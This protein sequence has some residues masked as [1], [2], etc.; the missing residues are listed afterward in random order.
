MRALLVEDNPADAR[1]IQEM[2]KA[3]PD[4]QVELQPVARLEAALKRLRQETFDLILL[5]LGLPDSQGLETLT[6]TAQAG[7]SSPIVVLTGRNDQAFALEALR[8]GAQDYLVK[9]HFDSDLLV[10]AIRY[11]VER[12]RAE[13]EVR[14]LNAE[15]EQRVA[16]RTA[17]LQTANQELLQ[18]QNRLTEAQ[19]IANVGDWEW[20]ISSDR[21]SASDQAYRMFAIEPVGSPLN[22]AAFLARVHPGDRPQVAKKL[23]QS[24]SAGAEYEME[25]RVLLPDGAV[26]WIFARGVV[27]RDAAGKPARMA[28]TVLDITDRKRVEEALRRSREDLDQA[29]QVGQIGSWR[30]DVRRNVLTWSDE[31]HRIFGVPKG[32][33]LTYETFL[34]TVH[35]DDRQLVDRQWQAALRGETY[36]IEHR[37]VVNGQVK[38]VRE[39]AFLE[40]DQAG[41]LLGGFGIT[42]DIT[43]RKQSEEKL[44]HSAAQIEAANAAL[45]EARRAAL[46]LM[47][48]AVQARRQTEQGNVYLRREIAER[49]RAEA[50]LR[51]LNRTLNA[52]SHSDQA[53]MRAQE[54]S[55][56]LKE[57][58]DLVVH[59]CG[60]AMVWIGYA[61]HDDEK[62]VRP[63][64]WA[65]FEEGYLETLKITWADTE[66]GRGPTGTAIRTG[67]PSLCRNMLTDPQFAPWREQAL[68]RGYRRPPLSCLC[69]PRGLSLASS[70]S[71][72]G[73]RI[74]SRR[75]RSSC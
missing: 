12:R 61:E 35:P 26:R 71:T 22:H 52:L 21:L 29:Q 7:G 30:L 53:F 5:D 14:R 1:L 2:L 56:Y 41:A 27:T 59:D 57:I 72:R 8:A 64:A 68:Q 62:S 33:P 13:E 50:D 60:H 46:N 66:R 74:P 18:S 75:T 11:A 3:W 40:L 10:R 44:R 70:T 54:E 65:G 63:V 19:R 51:R 4:G 55:A 36:D 48:D 38:W 45:E 15:L 25:Y 39:K 24:V 31:N 6:R 23:E 37:V 43:T 42:Q 17:Q 28:G 49:R 69:G 16:E 67:Q 20:D 9:G 47:D 34:G 32:T 73:S 58:C